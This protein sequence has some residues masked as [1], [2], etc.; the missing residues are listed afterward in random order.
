MIMENKTKSITLLKENPLLPAE[1]YTGMR[2]QGFSAIEKLGSDIWTEYNNSDPGIT[3]LEAVCY[4]ITDL[5]YRTGFEIKDLLAPE[6]LTGDTWKNIF[7]TARQILHNNPLTINDYRKLIIDVEGVRN[8]WVEPSKDYEVP[9]WIDYTYVETRKD[10]D[11]GCDKPALKKCYGKL[12]LDPLTKKEFEKRKNARLAELKKLLGSYSDKIDKPEEKIEF[13]NITK[14]TKF[15]KKQDDSYDIKI[16]VLK[17]RI[18]KLGKKPLDESDPFANVTLRQELKKLTNERDYLEQKVKALVE[19][20]RIINNS[21]FLDS[22]IIE[23]EGLYN[24]M[25]E[26]EEDV[27]EE[28]R[29]EGVRQRVVDRLAAHRNLCEDFLSVNA[30]EY[31]DF[32]IGGS[33]VLE[34]YADP[35]A[36]LAA[37]LFVVYKYFTPSVPFHTISQMLEKGYRVDEIFEGP[38]LHHGFIDDEELKITDLYRDIRLSDIINEIADIKGVK[39][40]TALH[41]PFN[42]NEP[43]KTG[44]YYFNQWV[45][46]L[47]EERKIARILPSHSSMLFC[48]EHDFITYNTG[49]ESD[50]NPARMLKMFSDLKKLERKY[51]LNGQAVDF[52]VPKGEFMELEDYFPVTYS[53]PMCYG[54]RDKLRINKTEEDDGKKT[55]K[56]TKR[57]VQALQLKGY[58][59]FFEQILSDYLVQLSHLKEFFSFDDLIDKTYFTRALSNI[60]EIEKKIPDLWDM[61]KLLIDNQNRGDDNFKQIVEDFSQVLQYIT[62]PPKLFTDR[63]NMF[64][65]HM[66]ARFGENINEYESVTK[67]LIPYKSG[68]RFIGDKTRIL[69][70]REYYRISSLR[71]KGYNYTLPEIWN[72]T[73]VSGT[74]RRI[75]RLLGFKNADR[76]SLSPDFIIT[77]PVMVT[78]EK[79]KSSVQKKNERGQPL[80]VI[81]LYNPENEEILLLT[82]VEVTEG[83]CTELLINEIIRCADERRYFKFREDLK[84]HSRKSAKVKGVFWFELWDDTDPEKATHLATGQKYDKKNELED[85]YRELQKAIDGINENEGLHLVE[86]LLLRPRIYEVKDETGKPSLV[87]FPNICLDEC[88]LGIGLGEGTEDP[89][90]RKKITRIPPDKCYD[91]M[92]WVLEYLIYNEKSK[93]Y[94]QSIL[95][96]KTFQEE[97]DP[98]LLKF[99]TYEAMAKRIMQLSEFGS[100]RSNY[101][102]LSNGNEELGKM[103]YS[104]VIYGKD[105]VVLAQSPYMFIK[106]NNQD[107]DDIE[108]VILKLMRHFKYQMDLYCEADPCDNDEDPYSFRT[109]I[110]LPCWPKRLRDET[111]RNLV[112]KTIVAES[113]AH[114]YSKVN[115]LGIGEMKRFEKVYFDWLQE[116]AQTEMPA[117]ESVNPLIDKINNLIPCGC[118]EDVCD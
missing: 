60:L 21:Q 9:V 17:D 105:K 70:D 92:P 115:W 15:R 82:S 69:K 80:N 94:D 2:K 39:A 35:D 16:N 98:I 103:K 36:V 62:E 1:D 57:E 87:S 20:G 58:L 73:N 42:S 25:V 48:K 88:D 99:R 100:E 6:N 7:Y 53:L 11:C 102:I 116:M 95:F 41:L 10:F 46:L 28:E 109:T 12:S 33:I 110:V 118:C 13:Y 4:A 54:I 47:K 65:N 112:E 3:I 8:A 108:T 113:P 45:E 101:E 91:K 27:I 37:V 75:S 93:K 29:R 19:E 22:K 86:H 83:C 26:Y 32:G 56:Y 72:T 59:L 104:F 68:E 14:N 51:K 96:Q 90:Y 31:E 23:L 84:Q 50:R 18:D 67:W 76:R 66:L 85:A 79:K 55:S 106:S 107:K 40:I 5:A 71:G 114:V 81:K 38:A 78:D 63:R 43:L 30:V 61:D 34:E 64:L 74:E 52:E 117:Y 89:P 44:S 97:K 24:V 77:E 111:F 49:R